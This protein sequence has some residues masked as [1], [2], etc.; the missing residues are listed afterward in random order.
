MT[1]SS[2]NPGQFPDAIECTDHFFREID[3]QFLIH[4][5]K[6]PISIIET[7]VRTLLEKQEKYGTLS[8]RQ[9]K[10]MKRVLRNVVKSREMLNNL[11]EIG[12]SEAGVCRS[13]PFHPATTA[14]QVL[15]DAIET[16]S[17]EIHESAVQCKNKVELIQFLAARHIS[18]DISPGLGQIEMCQDETRFRQILGN[19]IKNAL[20]HHK[21]R[22]DIQ[23]TKEG[24]FLHIAVADD[25][26]GIDPQHHGAVFQRYCQVSSAKVNVSRK[27]H[28]LGLAGALIQA[29]SLGGDIALKSEQGQGAVFILVLPLMLEP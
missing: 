2:K 15:I 28:G 24:D 5:M 23:M 20:Y 13:V 27:G 11:L 22:I 12:R 25:G 26:P 3:I 14:L 16:T 1:N 9:D 10:T 4:E 18:V 21:N 19:M 17:S 8:L 6:D 29:R 7:G